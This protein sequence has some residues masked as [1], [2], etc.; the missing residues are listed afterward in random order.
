MD[1]SC[2]GSFFHMKTIVTASCFSFFLAGLVSAQEVSPFTFNVGGGFTQTVGS[3]GRVLDNGWNAQAGAGWNFNAHLGALIQT[4]FDDVGINST[5]LSN[6]GYPGGNVHVFSATV[7]PI[8]HLH[9]RGH[10]DAYIIG[11]GGLAHVYQNFT[12]PTVATVTGFSPFFGFFTAGI[13]T[14]AVIAS[15]SVNKPGANI[16]MGFAFGTKWRAKMYAEARWDHVFM[17][18]GQRLDYVPVT[19]GVRY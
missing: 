13:P 3:T 7:D 12:A 15:T 14:T 10:W 11:G 2:E 5:T 17:N 16:G 19:F 4:Q 9:P 18:N 8:V 1:L 6:L